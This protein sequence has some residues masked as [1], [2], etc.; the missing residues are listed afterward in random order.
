[1]NTPNT[2]KLTLAV[3]VG[4]SGIKM[5]ILDEQGQPQTERARI[6]TPQP[7]TPDRIIPA[8]AQLASTVGEFDRVAVGFPAVVRNG[9]TRGAINLSP[10]WDGFD[11]GTALTQ[12]LGKPIRIAND[13][14]V[15]G[16]AAIAGNGVELVITLGTG[17]GSSLFVDGRLVPNL[18]LG[19][20]PFSDDKT[21][22]EHL[23]N[24]AFEKNGQKIW[25]RRLSKAIA[26]LAKLF[27]YEYLY[28]GGG[29]AKKIEIELPVN[30]KVISNKLGLLGGISLWRA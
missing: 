22:E 26:T 15:H 16:L 10:A 2:S 24:A 12:A 7:A 20:H 18:Q 25:N 11:L 14:D 3:D 1:M 19:Q 30:V 28:I 17:F 9:I 13:A 5:L 29:N 6:D 27:N 21:Y 4:G 8:I 23:G